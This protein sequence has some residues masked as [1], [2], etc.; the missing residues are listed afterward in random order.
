M[1]Y[2]TGIGYDIHRTGPDRAL[3]LAG[4]R[5]PC[6]WGLLGHSDAD[7]VLH[8][9]CDAILGAAALGDIGELFPDTDPAYEDADSRTLLADV[10][11]RAR[12]AGY[13][14]VNVDLIVHAEQPR[15]GPHKEA[16]RASL[17]RLLA[18]PAETVGL[19]ATTN[20]RLEAIGRGEA[21]A[22]WAAVL[23]SA[24]H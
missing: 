4:V 11:A 19:K 13:E 7:V 12:A 8:A 17:A 9:L 15:L 21:I 24:E 16:M 23:L 10:L 20:E 14:V 18:M 3:I 5:L 1:N 6:T 2:R 22:C